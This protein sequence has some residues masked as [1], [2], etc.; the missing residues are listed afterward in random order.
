MADY[1]LFM[2]RRKLAERLVDKYQRVSDVFTD[3]AMVYYEI[4]I[5]D[6]LVNLSQITTV[7]F[8]E[9]YEKTKRDAKL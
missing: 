3:E 7:N 1:D 6:V 5:N 4:G 9:K 8:V 2:L